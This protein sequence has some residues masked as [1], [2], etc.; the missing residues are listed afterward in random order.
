[1]L[2]IAFVAFAFG[3][4][5][6]WYFRVGALLTTFAAIALAVVVRVGFIGLPAGLIEGSIA[7]VAVQ[8]GYTASSAL[9]TRKNS[10]AK[11]KPSAW[12][13][14]VMDDRSGGGPAAPDN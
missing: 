12:R 1:M 5:L 8:L 11:W 9:A 4:C 10:P 2:Q 7:L 3:A 14:H 6:G 13:R